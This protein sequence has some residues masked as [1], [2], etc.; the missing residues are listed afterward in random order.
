MNVKAKRGVVHMPTF[1]NLRLHNITSGLSDPE[2][3]ADRHV[4]KK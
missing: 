1:A 4:D 2:H 3:R